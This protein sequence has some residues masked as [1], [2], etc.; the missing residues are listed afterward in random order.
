M[1]ILTVYSVECQTGLCAPI[2]YHVPIRAGINDVP[3][4][5]FRIAMM[6][7]VVRVPAVQRSHVDD[8]QRD[9]VCPSL[10]HT[11]TIFVVAKLQGFAY[12]ARVAGLCHEYALI[13]KRPMA[14]FI[15]LA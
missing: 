11:G 13:R 10:R 15:C 6:F 3:L 14:V 2:P 8:F 12:D 9:R 7:H 5:I 1:E 4:F